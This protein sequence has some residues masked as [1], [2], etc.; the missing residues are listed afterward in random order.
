MIRTYSDWEQAQRAIEAAESLDL[1][2]TLKR[3][4]V[5][6]TK[7]TPFAFP[8]DFSIVWEMEIRTEGEPAK[9]PAN[10]E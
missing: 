10:N 3:M 6:R 9:C 8:N 2:Y 4:T 5:P 1:D 7:L